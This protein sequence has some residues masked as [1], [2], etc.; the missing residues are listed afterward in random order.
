MFQIHKERD[1][2]VVYVDTPAGLLTRRGTLFGVREAELN[3]LTKPLQDM[4]SPTEIIDRTES[5]ISSERQ[6]PAYFLL[7]G[8]VLVHPAAGMVLSLG[9]A[10]FWHFQKSAFAGKWLHKTMSLLSNEFVFMALGVLA[11]SPLGT[12]ARYAELAVSMVLFLAF[13]FGWISAVLNRWSDGQ[14]RQNTRVLLMTVRKACIEFNIH[15]SE[16]DRME[17]DIFLAMA[18][19]SSLIKQKTKS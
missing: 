6:L 19:F 16:L 3:Q 14:T 1:P 11:I 2:A 12:A 17:K 18:Q 5:V 4:I 7:A 13:R 15:T 8:I 10:A 9:F